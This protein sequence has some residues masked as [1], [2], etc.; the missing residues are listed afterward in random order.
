[1]TA[2]NARFFV[3]IN[4]RTISK[5]DLL[6][7]DSI[8]NLRHKILRFSETVLGNNQIQLYVSVGNVV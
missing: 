3:H 5:H 8:A 2:S 1:M 7:S 6:L 4:R